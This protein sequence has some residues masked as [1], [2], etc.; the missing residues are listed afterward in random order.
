V[1][2]GSRGL[3]GL[4]EIFLGSVSHHVVQKSSCPVMIVK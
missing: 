4:K 1:V 2:M 3:S